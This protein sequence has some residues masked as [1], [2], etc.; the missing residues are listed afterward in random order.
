M[1]SAETPIFVA[2]VIDG[3]TDKMDDSVNTPTTSFFVIS[4]SI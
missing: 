3:D 2:I 1:E 4:E